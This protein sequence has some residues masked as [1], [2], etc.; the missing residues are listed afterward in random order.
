MRYM[1]CYIT[2]AVQNK[3]EYIA[4]PILLFKVWNVTKKFL[5]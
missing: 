4:E 3:I 1:L 2:D 5:I